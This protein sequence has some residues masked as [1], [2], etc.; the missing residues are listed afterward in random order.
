MTTGKTG[1]V[2]YCL[3]TTDW[4]INLIALFSNGKGFQ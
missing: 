2:V 4:Q 3:F 1:I